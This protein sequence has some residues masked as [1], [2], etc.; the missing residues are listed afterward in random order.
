MYPRPCGSST[1]PLRVQ[2]ATGKP[3][4]DQV[5]RCWVA[6]Q[7]GS[8]PRA[9]GPGGRARVQVMWARSRSDVRAGRPLGDTSSWPTSSRVRLCGRGRQQRK[10]GARERGGG[11]MKAG[12]EPGAAAGSVHNT[13]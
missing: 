2:A 5:F 3:H 7:G 6:S 8:G 13:V 9:G 1:A 10:G 12:C 4:S 11:W